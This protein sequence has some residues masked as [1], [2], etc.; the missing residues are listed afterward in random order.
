LV[1]GCAG[2]ALAADPLMKFFRILSALSEETVAFGFRWVLPRRL[3]VASSI[4]VL[5]KLDDEFEAVV[6]FVVDF[7]LFLVW[8]VDS[9]VSESKSRRKGS[10]VEL[11]ASDL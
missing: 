5:T 4:S 3:D 9:G 11:V 7:L 1:F 8:V 6:A 2:V 10:K